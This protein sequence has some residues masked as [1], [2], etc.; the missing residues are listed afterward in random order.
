[1]E[2]SRLAADASVTDEPVPLSNEVAPTSTTLLYNIQVMDPEG[3]RRF[4]HVYGPL[5]YRWCRSSGL[6]EADAADVG[7]EVFQAV[8]RAIGGFR[9]DQAGGTFRGWLRTIT[10]N[11]VRDFARRQVTQTYGGGGS[12]AREKLAQVAAEPSPEADESPPDPEEELILLRRAVELVL[13]DFKDE[14]RQAFLMVVVDH[15]DPAEVARE[16]G[17]SV[18]VVYLAKSRIMRKL[19]EEFAD[20]LDL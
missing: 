3:W 15:R 1:L 9:R 17:V 5:V 13:A 16:L 10:R 2:H 20:V 14:T 8:A 7:Q 11:K 18:N 6:Q 19:R 4:V 12:E